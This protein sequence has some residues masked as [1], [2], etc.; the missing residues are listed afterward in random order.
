MQ[1]KPTVSV[2]IPVYNQK[3]YLTETI[4]S[5]LLQTYSD[6]ELILINDGSSDNSSQIIERAAEKDPRIVAIH[7]TNQGKPKAINQAATVAKGEILAFMDHDD[8]MNPERLEKQ[9]AYL[10]AHRE[11]SAVSSNCEY[12][13]EKGFAMGVQR[14]GQ[15]GSPEACRESIRLKKRV[16][17]AFTALTIRKEAFNKIGGLR[18]RFWPSDDID[19]I[20]RIPQN[21][22]LLVILEDVL[23]K[24]RIHSRSTTSANQWALFRMADYTNYCVEQ[25]NLNAQEP[26][27]EEFKAM[28]KKEGWWLKLKRSGH[29]HSIIL[30]QKAHFYLTLK[31]YFKFLSCFTR[32]FFLDP[33]YVWSN[34]RKRL[35]SEHSS[36]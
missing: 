30:L 6:F 36:T 26:T 13:N 14:F 8:I 27:F 22:F 24:Y 21:G 2:I 31:E 17:C 12:V 7:T 29:N 23:V 11:V 3:K 4:D 32:A 10:N 35:N 28:R 16:M 1:K 18:S 15:L 5:V 34:V 19:F 20:N 33:R 25:R 9:V